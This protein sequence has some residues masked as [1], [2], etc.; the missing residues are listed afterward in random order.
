[1]TRLSLYRAAP[2]GACA[3]C[4]EPKGRGDFC[5]ERPVYVCSRTTCRRTWRALEVAEE[6]LHQKAKESLRRVRL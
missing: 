1:M 5:G 6:E 3:V 4:W 2:Q